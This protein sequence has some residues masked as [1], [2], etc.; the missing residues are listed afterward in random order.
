MSIVVTITTREGI[1]MGA[2]SRLTLTF[3]DP[4]A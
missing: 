2:D 4:N 3:P 1:V